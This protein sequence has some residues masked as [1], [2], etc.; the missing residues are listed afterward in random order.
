MLA[1]TCNETDKESIARPMSKPMMRTGAQEV[2]GRHWEG[3]V[4]K[5]ARAEVADP[6]AEKVAYWGADWVG[7]TAAVTVAATAE[8]KAVGATGVVLGEGTGWGRWWW[9]RRWR[10]WWWCWWR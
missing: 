8:E 3:E 5:G 6:A 4:P 7:E 9:R 2:E 10:G 1:C